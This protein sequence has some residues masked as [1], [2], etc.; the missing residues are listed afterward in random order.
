MSPRAR[1]R[2]PPLMPWARASPVRPAASRSTSCNRLARC[3]STWTL[4]ATQ[5]LTKLSTLALV[6]IVLGTAAGSGR[7]LGALLDRRGRGVQ[8]GQARGLG[9]LGLLG[10][11]QSAQPRGLGILGGARRRQFILHQLGAALPDLEHAV[12]G[13]IRGLLG[14]G[15]GNGA[16]LKK[17]DRGKKGGGDAVHAPPPVFFRRPKDW[18]PW[19]RAHP[20]GCRNSP[21]GLRSGCAGPP[22]R[23]R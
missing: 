5:S 1:L 22:L 16:L 3:G 17:R 11:A 6:C 21:S 15:I 14:F 12:G 20:A 13:A 10:Q 8:G 23:R 19:N 7:A 4:R 9:V 18:R 2:S